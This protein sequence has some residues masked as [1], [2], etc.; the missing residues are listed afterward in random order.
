MQMKK[1]LPVLACALIS[2]PA[3]AL[4]IVFEYDV[5]SAFYTQERRDAL[6]WAA[7][8]YEQYIT[9]DVN[10]YVSLKSTVDTDA[11]A[12]G[13]P[14]AWY[15]DFQMDWRGEIIFS[16]SWD[17]YSGAGESFSGLDLFSVALHELGHVLGVGILDPW[18][19]LVADGHFFGSDAMTSYGGPVPVDPFGD[20]WRDDIYSTLPGTGTWQ[21]AA[22]NPFISYGERQYLTD[23]DLAGLKDMGWDVT[24][25]PEPETLYMLLAG[26]GIVGLVARR[27]RRAVA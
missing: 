25:I 23:L 9:N 1:M 27:Q 16:E 8:F 4:D 21:L 20:H 26:L 24:A 3:L 12:W 14:S 15:N 17:W 7:S 13:G 5:N 11:L 6:E 18:T 22:Y 2:S 19:S 10:I